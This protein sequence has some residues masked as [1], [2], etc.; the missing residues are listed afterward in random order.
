M[1]QEA[2]QRYLRP[3]IPV[4]A[5]LLLALL[6]VPAGLTPAAWHYFAL[7]AAVV[8]AMITEPLPAGAVGLLGVTVASLL[9]LIGA[10]SAEGIKWA[11]SGFADPTVWL[12]FGAFVFATG[13][14]KTG[15]GR[16]IALGL[17]KRLGGRTLGLG[18]AIALT[19]LALA[20][21]T[22]SNTG[23]SAGIIY[24]IVRGLPELYGSAPGPTARRIGAYLMWTSFAATAVTS[25]MFLTALAPNP[26]A[27]SIAR[28]TVG[29]APSWT[30]WFIGFL[31]VGVL[32]LAL[33][34]LLTYL[35]YPPE[36]RV[37][38]EV[39][40]WAGQELARMGPTTRK[41]RTMAVLVLVALS[42]W[43]FGGDRIH[44]TQTVL[45]VV[46]LLLVTRVVLWE[47]LLAQRQ[48]WNV[49]IWFATLLTMADGLARVGFVAW[50]AQRASGV[51]QPLPAGLLVVAFV[52]LFFFAHYLFA[53]LVAHTTALLPVV[54]AAAMGLPGLPLPR[55]TL[56]LCY[57]IGL[58]GVLHPYATGPA[59]VYY[60]SGFISRRH[61]WLL[62]L[63]FGTVFLVA[64]VT[65]GNLW[66]G[67]S[68]P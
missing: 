31:P 21:F 33:V 9:G 66:L 58:M 29:L 63:L 4:A 20:P 57:A 67:L 53:S 44:A 45:I 5:G 50:V 28:K 46:G 39:P 6:P 14:E 36:I 38:P 13:Y 22:P 60:G 61:F 30:E 10:T 48:A 40:V 12:I 56:L 55:L 51:L 27:L 62:G 8:L 24:P 42:L 59:V 43:I 7:F 17:V 41:E 25:S 23:R 35:V 1:G 2:A 52:A 49:L 11:L 65:L 18:Y 64:L 19:D 15:L 32:L 54:L 26:L 37:S 68:R 34:P 47:D 3:G 16:R